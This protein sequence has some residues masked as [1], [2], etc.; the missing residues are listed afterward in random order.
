MSDF[1]LTRAVSCH[2]CF[3]FT[4]TFALSIGIF[5]SW[6]AS[7]CQRRRHRRHIVCK[8]EDELEHEAETEAEDETKTETEAEIEAE[9]EDEAVAETESDAN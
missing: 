7:L 8:A 3:T 5:S 1:K 4:L 9:T 6:A 2:I